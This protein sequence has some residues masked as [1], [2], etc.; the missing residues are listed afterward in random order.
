VLGEG[1]AARF[2]PMAELPGVDLSPTAAAVLHRAFGE[3][4]VGPSSPGPPGR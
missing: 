4:L 3:A 2:V 1:I